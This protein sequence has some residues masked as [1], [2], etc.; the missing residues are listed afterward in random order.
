MEQ[1]QVRASG[2]QW[3]RGGGRVL[4][5]SLGHTLQMDH[6]RG[7]ADRTLNRNEWKATHPG[8]EAPCDVNLVMSMYS[9]Q[10]LK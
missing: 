8:G 3:M 7:W 1:G 10:T 2:G 5:G 9:L 6:P 4:L